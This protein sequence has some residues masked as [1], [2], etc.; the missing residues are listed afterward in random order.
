MYF[1]IFDGST[2]FD[3][4]RLFQAVEDILKEQCVKLQNEAR[5]MHL[6][7]SF[8]RFLYPHSYFDAVTPNR[9]IE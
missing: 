1:E 8:R 2:H 6:Y 9:A 5:K 7:K 3:E 4:T